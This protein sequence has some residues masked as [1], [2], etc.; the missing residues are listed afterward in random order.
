MSNPKL[1]NTLSIICGI[2]FL[3]F[4]SFWPY[5]ANLV[6]AYPVGFLGLYFWSKA[7][8]I[9]PLNKVNKAAFIIFLVGF[10]I[11]MLSLVVLLAFN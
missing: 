11:S 6:V 3:L 5:F 8:K 9:D 10:S 4:G 7:R 2:W 1:Y